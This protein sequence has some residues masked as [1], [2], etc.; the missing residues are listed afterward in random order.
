MKRHEILI[1]EHLF[2]GLLIFFEPD[3]S[4]ARNHLIVTFISMQNITGMTDTYLRSTST[5]SCRLVKP[6]LVLV[7]R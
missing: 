4:R 1:V 2:W 6:N 7:F 3:I 5:E